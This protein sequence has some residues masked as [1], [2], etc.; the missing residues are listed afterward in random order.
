MTDDELRHRN[1]E[2]QRSWRATNPERAI[3]TARAYEEANGER[4]RAQKQASY[5]RRHAA[6]PERFRARGRAYV[7]AHLEERRERMLLRRAFIDAAMAGGCVD[8][9][10]K[11]QVVL[12]LD[13]V[14]GTKVTEV[15]KLLTASLPRLFAELDKCET[16]CANCHRRATIARR[17]LAA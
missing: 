12:E 14:R 1:R 4:R 7:A 2:N 17:K 10:T 15:S 13:H 16:R 5:L 11:E 9:G 3:A 6:D 8:C